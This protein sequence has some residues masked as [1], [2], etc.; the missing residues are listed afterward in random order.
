MIGK[1]TAVEGLRGRFDALRAVLARARA[2]ALLERLR[3]LGLV[4]TPMNQHDGPY[5]VPTS[6]EQ[7]YL[8]VAISGQSDVTARLEE[9]EHLRIDLL[10]TVAHELRWR[11]DYDRETALGQGSTFTLRVPAQ[12]PPETEEA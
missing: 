3:E 8:H 12:G 11:D 6:L 1:G 7:R 4:Y 9:L 5:Y 10:S 2:A